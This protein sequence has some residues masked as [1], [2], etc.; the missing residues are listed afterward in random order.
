MNMR[1]VL[2]IPDL[3]MV[4]NERT[5]SSE[6]SNYNAKRCLVVIHLGVAMPCY[7]A[8][9]CT[10]EVRSMGLGTEVEFPHC[11]EDIETRGWDTS[12]QLRQRY[13]SFLFSCFWTVY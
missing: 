1:A 7:T 9:Y 5:S 12:Q 10:S 3:G 8:V 13:K 4:D 6:S 11:T 2:R